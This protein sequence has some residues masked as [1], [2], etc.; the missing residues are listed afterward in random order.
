MRISIQRTKTFVS[1]ARGLTCLLLLFFSHSSIG[2]RCDCRQKLDWLRSTFEAN[3]AGFSYGLERKGAE[4][5]QAHNDVLNERVTTITDH[6]AC[7]SALRDWVRFFRLG[8][9]G[10]YDRSQN[11]TA[12]SAEPLTDEQIK[13]QY[14]DWETYE[15]DRKAFQQRIAGQKM[16][17]FEGVWRSGPY[18]VGI[19]KVNDGYVGFILEADGVYW[20]KDQIKLR[21]HADSSATFYMRNHSERS[22]DNASLIGNNYLQLGFVQFT[23]VDSP[24]ESPPGMDRYFQLRDAS[25]A[26]YLEVN[27]HTAL[28]RI[29]S[30]NG[31]RKDQ[32]DEVIQANWDQITSKA[33]LI[34]DIRN[35]GG[36]SDRSYQELLP[37]LYTNPIR[38][39]G[40]EYR[41]TPLN[42]QRM[43]DFISDPSYGFS[44]EEKDWARESHAKL[45]DRLGQFVSLD[46]DPIDITTYDEV[47]PN[48][49]HVAILI[50][51][52]N[53]STAEQFLLAAKQSRKV[54]LFGTT[55]GG[56][57]DISNMY[58]VQSPCEDF[59]LR[60]C[61]SRS[62][63]I[64]DMTVD[65]KGIMP[66]YYIDGSVAPHQWVEFV[67]KQLG[68]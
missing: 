1:L 3:D 42:N 21:I 58:S 45:A 36:G 34:I 13:A 68:Q 8:H 49:Q 14:A 22:F 66:D 37:L 65:E 7:L 54:K 53:A 19:E 55:T 33:N 4:A 60:Y 32:I 63:R 31:G 27:P 46:E 18:L 25:E 67:L 6:Q 10:V 24:F 43:L 29:P 62:L 26:M 40:V 28:L 44:E 17:S 56:V 30:F 59:E 41:S 57:L 23:R 11:E 35:N 39:I 12:S 38:S 64:P 9:F 20:T 47:L 16:P 2:Q 51:G 50:N 15:S 52:N 5:Y 48:P 61:L